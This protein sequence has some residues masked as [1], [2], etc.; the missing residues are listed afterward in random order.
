MKITIRIILFISIFSYS[1]IVTAGYYD[2]LGSPDSVNP[3]TTRSSGTGHSSVYFNPAAIA[4]FRTGISF[5]ISYSLLRPNISY[6]SKDSSF[7][8]P[9]IIFESIPAST[10]TDNTYIRPLPTERLRNPR[11]NSS[12]F[13]QTAHFHIGAVASIHE[14]RV[15]IGFLALLPLSS[16]QTQSPFF[17]DEREQFFSNSL[18]HEM[19][20]DRIENN[21]FSFAIAGKITEWLTLG[22]GLTMTTSA[23]SNTDL[24]L[25]DASNQ[26]ESYLNSSVKVGTSFVPHFSALFP[27]SRNFSINATVHFE[28]LSRTQGE[29]YIQFWNYQEDAEPTVQKFNFVYGFEPLRAS[30]G[31]KYDFKSDG[32]KISTFSNI[33]FS[34]WSDY[35]DRHGEKPLDSWND[36]VSISTGLKTTFGIHSLGFDLA[37]VP[38]PVPLQDGRTNYVDNSRIVFGGGYEYQFSMGGKSLSFTVYGVAHLLLKETVSK[39]PASSNPVIDEFPDSVN[40]F[41]DEDVAESHG[42]QTNNPGFPGYTTDGWIFT[43]GASLKMLF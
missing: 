29:S 11:G 23:K 22:A 41:T 38:T 9:G 13:S 37:F 31:I 26:E 28:S 10:A 4:G 34:K 21:M 32:L 6:M 30:T 35:I 24:Y 18:H 42:F 7:D 8:I 20:G 25:P 16:F 43:A 2:Y 27:V 19:H 12:T 1:S 14:N 17:S 39:N 33:I 5:G 40:I 3:L 15:A 36:T